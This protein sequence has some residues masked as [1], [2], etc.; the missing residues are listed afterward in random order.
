MTAKQELMEC[1]QNLT[2]E[3][4]PASPFGKMPG[5]AGTLCNLHGCLYRK[6]VWR[7]KQMKQ[8]YIQAINEAMER[9]NDIPLLDLIYQIL[10]KHEVRA[11]N[12]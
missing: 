5:V 11:N 10:I 3:R 9:T 7:C 8:E 6:A 2:Q 1:I 12:E 4:F